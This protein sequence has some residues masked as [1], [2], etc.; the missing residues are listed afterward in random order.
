MA[1]LNILGDRVVLNEKL[2]YISNSNS[3][4]RILCHRFC[5]RRIILSHQDSGLLQVVILL[6]LFGSPA[7]ISYYA[8]KKFGIV[9][10]YPG[11][12][13][14]APGLALFITELM[15]PNTNPY[16]LLLPISILLLISLPAGKLGLKHRGASNA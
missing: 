9:W 11:L 3:S 2:H 13:L 8:A 14:A 1:A 5:I 15:S 10:W 12:L 16:I 7:F 4:F 6:F